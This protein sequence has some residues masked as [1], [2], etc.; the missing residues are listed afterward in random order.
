MVTM[1]KKHS[2]FVFCLLIF[3]LFLARNPFSSRTLIPNFEPYPDAIHYVVPARNFVINT[4]FAIVREGRVIN[5]RVPPLYSLFLIPFYALNSDPRFFYFGNVL[6]ALCSFFLFYLIIKQLSKNDFRPL[7]FDSR[8]ITKILIFFPLFLYITNYFNYWYPTLAMSEN[9][10]IF[11]FLLNLFILINPVNKVTA[12]AGGII[13]FAFFITKYAHI[14]LTV[15][16]LIAYGIKVIIDS[17]RTNKLLFKKWGLYFGTSVIIA[18]LLLLYFE[19]IPGISSLIDY[20]KIL[21]PIQKSGSQISNSAGGWFSVLYM[22]EH[23]PK[24]IRAIFGGYS[25]RFL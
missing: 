20:I 17:G 21:F 9:L 18:V 3:L 25:V 23:L 6:L 22:K 15:V 2:I 24:Y 14:P 7:T 10:T 16:F 5:P 12:I 1:I 4:Q 11:L 13:P 8:L 19:L